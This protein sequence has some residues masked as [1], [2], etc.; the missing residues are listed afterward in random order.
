MTL[1]LILN[2]FETSSQNPRNLETRMQIAVD[3]DVVA[4]L[5]LDV[6]FFATSECREM[7]DFPCFD[8]RVKRN[9]VR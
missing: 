7:N 5:Y 6:T 1:Y 8:F 2:Q 4:E 3:E 9:I